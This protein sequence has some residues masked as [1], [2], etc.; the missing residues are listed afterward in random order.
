MVVLTVVSAVVFL[1][2]LHILIE[3]G[4]MLIVGYNT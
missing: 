4:V 3:K 1:M 2:G